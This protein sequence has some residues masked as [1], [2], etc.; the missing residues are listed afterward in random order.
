MTAR[1]SPREQAQAVMFT[2]AK[3]VLHVLTARFFAPHGNVALQDLLC[4]E[5]FLRTQFCSNVSVGCVPLSPLSTH[6][7]APVI[8][9]APK[10]HSS[11]QTASATVH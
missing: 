2:M 11:G 4:G 5:G 8:V 6:V 3:Q 9:E 10:P 7:T 1:G